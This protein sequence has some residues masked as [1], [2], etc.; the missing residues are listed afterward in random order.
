MDDYPPFCGYIMVYDPTFES[1]WWKN[2]MKHPDTILYIYKGGSIHLLTMAQG[3]SCGLYSLQNPTRIHL[4]RRW[5]PKKVCSG[6]HWPWQ[7]RGALPRDTGYLGMSEN[8]MNPEIYCYS[9]QWWSPIIAI[10]GHHFRKTYL[11]RPT[12]EVDWLWFGQRM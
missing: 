12:G 9:E 1:S 5:V 6:S 7:V 2:P 3:H 11:D 10:F 4:R 8:R